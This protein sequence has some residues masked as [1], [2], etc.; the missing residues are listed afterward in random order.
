MCYTGEVHFKELLLFLL[1]GAGLLVLAGYFFWKTAEHDTYFVLPS[2]QPSPHDTSPASSPLT[3]NSRCGPAVAIETWAGGH[4]AERVG[5]LYKECLAQTTKSSCLRVD[6][7]HY[8]RDEWIPDGK[9]D[10]QWQGE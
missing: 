3:K 4:D 2:L 5:N 10:C 1:V 6:W 9:A 8:D 7:F